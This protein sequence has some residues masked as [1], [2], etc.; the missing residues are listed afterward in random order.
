[1]DKKTQDHIKLAIIAVLGTSYFILHTALTVILEPEG[2][3]KVFLIFAF[4]FI[5]QGMEYF[6]T[7]SSEDKK[8]WITP[9]AFRFG[10]Y[11]IPLLLYMA[12][13]GLNAMG[14]GEQLGDTEICIFVIICFNMMKILIHIAIELNDNDDDDDR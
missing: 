10:G 1:M 7:I 12:A 14:I 2:F 8:A 13:S 9:G 6:F 5:A 3:E 11:V 4:G